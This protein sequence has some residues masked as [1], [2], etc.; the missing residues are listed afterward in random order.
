MTLQSRLRRLFGSSSPALVGH[1]TD[2]LGARA[3][4]RPRLS[5]VEDD[6]KEDQVAETNPHPL[7]DNGTG[8]IDKLDN[9]SG[10]VGVDQRNNE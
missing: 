1:L 5:P 9:P 3:E 6:K 8:L 4:D 2:N 10:S 7:R